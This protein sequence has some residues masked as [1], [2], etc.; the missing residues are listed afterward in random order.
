MTDNPAVALVSAKLA[1][2]PDVAP[3]P[4]T[5]R[6]PTLNPAALHGVVGDYVRLILPHTEANAAALLACALVALGA[7]IG[8]D[9]FWYFGDTAHHVRLFVLLIGPSGAGR[10]GTTI[11]ASALRL[12]RW[13]DSA[14]LADR[15]ARGL[16]SAEGLLMLIRDATE[17]TVQHGKTIPGD[18]GITDKRL[19]VIEE[20]F[21]ATL[22][23]ME[24]EGN[25][26]PSILRTAWDGADMGSLVKVA[27]IKATQAHVAI[28]GA[29]TPTELAKGLRVVAIRGGL[30]NR[31]LPVWT[32]RA[33]LLPYDSEPNP[34]ELQAVLD[35]LARA[36]VTART[37]R[38]MDWTPEARDLWAPMYADLAVTPHESETVRALL[39]RGAPYVRRLAMLY[40]LLDGS[41]LVDVPHLTAARALWDYCA[42]TWRVVY[43]EGAHRSPL[44]DRLLT[45]LHD[46]G[47][48]GLTGTQL[49][50][51]AGSN[52]IAAA[53][54]GDELNTLAVDGLAQRETVATGGRRR[55]VWRHARYIG[56]P[57]REEREAGEE[58]H[59]TPPSLPS[60]PLLPPDDGPS[61]DVIAADGPPL[62]MEDAA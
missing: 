23:A 25:K 56:A 2:L 51:A 13:L 11:A 34:D 61:L 38:R 53:K 49:R 30:A 20:E 22:A 62:D 58:T 6:P 37:I 24:R 45:A 57:V 17:D 10:K 8:R 27:P 1:A 36:V 29:I 18:P 46:A 14:F 59:T 19:L 44:A 50:K 55:T 43:A 31:F 16:S 60:L 15:I 12:L 41:A 54:I 26:L 9:P 4:R 32:S 28:I 48:E 7:L 52:D 40:A 42:A 47:A 21:G 35:R 5:V 3:T 39:Q 33:Q